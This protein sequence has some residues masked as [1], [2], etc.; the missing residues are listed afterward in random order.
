ML[1]GTKLMHTL[2]LPG[3]VSRTK[4]KEVN[5]QVRPSKSFADLIHYFCYYN[6]PFLFLDSVIQELRY[7]GTVV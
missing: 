4:P 2:N 1:I 5:K 6:S 3:R 7:L